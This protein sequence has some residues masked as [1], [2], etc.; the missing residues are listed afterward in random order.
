LKFRKICPQLQIEFAV[1]REGGTKF[2]ELEESATYNLDF[3]CLSFS[4]NVDQETTF[5]IPML[6]NKAQVLYS[7][8]YHT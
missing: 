6:G 7:T 8:I 4:E 1:L 2:A 5:L 3:A